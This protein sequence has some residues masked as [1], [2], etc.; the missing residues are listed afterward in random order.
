MPSNLTEYEW[1]RFNELLIKVAD[2]NFATWQNKKENTVKNLSPSAAMAMQEI[3][4]W[5]WV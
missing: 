1:M 3:A 2:Q 4:S 5:E